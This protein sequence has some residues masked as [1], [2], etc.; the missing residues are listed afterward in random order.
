MRQPHQTCEKCD[1][2]A[3]LP[4]A[5]AANKLECRIHPPVV[6]VWNNYPHTVWPEVTEDRWCG[7]WAPSK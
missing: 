6:L 4:T 5:T 3:T 1:H 7:S 2:C